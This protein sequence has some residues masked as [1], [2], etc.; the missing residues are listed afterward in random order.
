MIKEADIQ[1]LEVSIRTWLD[2]MD[3]IFHLLRDENTD[4]S[5]YEFSH[6]E[7]AREYK[8]EFAFL[9]DRV[10]NS[11]LVYFELKGVPDYKGD[12]IKSLGLFM[13]RPNKE[14]TPLSDLDF[15]N[16]YGSEESLITKLFRQNLF[17]FRAFGSTD[18]KHLTGL[19]YLEN[20]L[21]STNRI[22]K[23][24]N[25]K[26]TKEAEVYN[27]VK[28]VIEATFSNS[29]ASYPGGQKKVISQMAKCYIPDILIPDLNCAIEYKFA[30]SEKDLNETIDQVL[31]DVKG[32]SN[33][34]IYNRFYAV[35]YVK[36]GVTTEMRFNQIWNEKKFPSNWRPIF[37]EG[38]VYPKK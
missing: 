14:K 32:Y 34:L 36:T 37:I 33:D 7:I 24:R 15:V 2:R 1:Y 28:L 23:E 17:P 30:K 27:G 26:P 5:E 10:Y 3:E 35:F 38:P 13:K 29:K 18:S 16:I 11:C 4:L 12:F 19:D 25:I 8:R 31:V 6:K 9:T 22:L 20:V 21:K